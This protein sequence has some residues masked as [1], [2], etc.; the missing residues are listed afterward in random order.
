MPLRMKEYSDGS[1]EES[2]LV[3]TSGYVSGTLCSEGI[4]CA[5]GTCEKD[6]TFAYSRCVGPE[7][8]NDQDC[9]STS[10]CDSGLC[11]LKLGSCM[12][13]NEDSDCA[14]NN[15]LLYRC[16][17]ENGLMDNNCRSK[18]DND[19]DSERCEGM[20]PP[21]CKAQLGGGSRCNENSDCHSDRCT[22]RFRCRD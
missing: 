1:N 16:S 11:L 14:G 7:C 5:S 15:C 22:W 3:R 12:D 9:A 4:E 19:C 17:N 20:F 8:E 6:V 2:Y 10:R 18:W 13:C 21:V